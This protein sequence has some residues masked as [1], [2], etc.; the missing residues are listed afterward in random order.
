MSKK[1]IFLSLAAILTTTSLVIYFNKTEVSAT[2]TAFTDQGR[3]IMETSQKLQEAH[4]KQAPPPPALYFIPDT[5]S[6]A[7]NQSLS[8]SV[9]AENNILTAP[10]F[11]VL[12]QRTTQTPPK[13]I[14]LHSDAV[15][16]VDDAWLR[17][18]YNAGIAIVAL[19]TLVSELGTKLGLE[20]SIA[21]FE[22]LR[23]ELTETYPYFV[24]FHKPSVPGG[25]SG[26]MITADFL[27][28]LD[29]LPFIIKPVIDTYHLTPE[30]LNALT[31]T[32]VK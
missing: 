17:Q 6:I 25:A 23:P 4:L 28:N 7:S 19:N 13:V 30:F 14:Y 27:Q 21:D 18:Q 3:C 22:D 31:D 20:A 9:L 1:L 32:C 26:E 2:G 29:D 24:L 15:N 5:A 10:S 12:K 8:P 16:R 11:E